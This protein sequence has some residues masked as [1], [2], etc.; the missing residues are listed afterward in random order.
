[1][2]L[3]VGSQAL[4]KYVD[5]NRSPKDIDVIGT[6][7]DV[8]TYV[9]FL[10]GEL[11]VA[12]PFNNGKKYLF[13]KSTDHESGDIIVEAEIAWEGSLAEEFL[14]LMDDVGHKYNATLNGLYT[15]KMSHRYLRNSPHFLKTMRDIQL[16]RKL[17]AKIP[18]EL[19]DFFIRRERETY[20][21]F[22]PSLQAS[23]KNFFAGDGVEYV[24][25]HDSIHQAVKLQDRP[26]YSYFK[27]DDKE[28]FVS[29]KLFENLDDTTKMNSVLEESYVLAIERSQV[30]HPGV[31]TPRQSF[32]IAL[33]KVCSSITSGWWR[34]YAWEH[35]DD[36][37]KHY[38]DSYMNR[39][40]TGIENGVVKPFSD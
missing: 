12:R 33:R 10:N 18:E 34:E 15:L 37:I 36:A 21:Y 27:S 4:K 23:K 32:D 30:P 19:K 35:Y 7:E 31:L 6:Y 14:A 38:D 1:M 2:V 22:H 39:F 26:A 11:K 3:L 29:K 20:D 16:M 40:N 9:K 25:D 17:G 13:V 8:S 24:Y 28:V 5:L